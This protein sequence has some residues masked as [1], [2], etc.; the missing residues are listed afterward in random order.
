MACAKPIADMLHAWMQSQRQMV[1][2]WSAIAKE[3]DYN[4]KRWNALVRYF[5]NAYLPIDNNWIENQIKP[6]AIGR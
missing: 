4:L 1:P 6:E 2:E 3:L 5:D